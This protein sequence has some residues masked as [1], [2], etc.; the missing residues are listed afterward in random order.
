VDAD[1][2]Q[3]PAR[4]GALDQPHGTYRYVT[5]SGL[6]TFPIPYGERTFQIDFDFMGHELGIQTGEGEVRTLA[7]R[8]QPVAESYR[9]LLS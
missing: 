1:R 3:D 6:T 9:D 8:P 4:A 2:G 7:L 5:S